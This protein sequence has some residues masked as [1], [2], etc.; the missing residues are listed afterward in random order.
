MGT[1]IGSRSDAYAHTRTRSYTVIMGEKKIDEAHGKLLH[2]HT[3]AQA[4]TLD[5]DAQMRSQ[6]GVPGLSKAE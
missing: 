5:I 1:T 6:G 2:L 3:L 4:V